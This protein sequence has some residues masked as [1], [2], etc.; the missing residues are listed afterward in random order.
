M[1]SAKEH[2]GVEA[3]GNISS[4]D[5]EICTL[6]QVAEQLRLVVVWL[7]NHPEMAWVS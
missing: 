7:E 5:L 2:A 3:H 1:D 4:G 6:V